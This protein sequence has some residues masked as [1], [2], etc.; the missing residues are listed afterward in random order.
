MSNYIYAS[1]FPREGNRK[2][3]F[4]PLLACHDPLENEHLLFFCGT[5][6]VAHASASCPEEMLPE[7]ARPQWHV[8]LAEDPSSSFPLPLI[9]CV[10]VLV[11]LE[12][13]NKTFLINLLKLLLPLLV[14]TL[15][16]QSMMDLRHE[17]A[18]STGN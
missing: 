5:I 8:V 16:L 18:A 1:R 11:L 10:C 7:V 12:R 13:F 9:M 4:L 15:S 17:P 6:P 2:L 3:P 14:N